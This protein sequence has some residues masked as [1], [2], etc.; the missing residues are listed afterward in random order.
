MSYGGTMTTGNNMEI[1]V[2]SGGKKGTMCFQSGKDGIY[3][4]TLE[5]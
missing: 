4:K 2:G 1:T 3:S 5:Y